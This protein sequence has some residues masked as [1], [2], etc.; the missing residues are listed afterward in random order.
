MVQS[1]LV[2][3]LVRRPRGFGCVLIGQSRFVTKLQ[4]D[5]SLPLPSGVPT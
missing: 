3:R 1:G 2:S 5:K 4:L